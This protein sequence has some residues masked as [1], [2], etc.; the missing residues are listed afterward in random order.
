M[1]ITYNNIY[2]IFNK[3]RIRYV[4]VDMKDLRVV[5]SISKEMIKE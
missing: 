3:V 5:S 2:V 1:F 4:H